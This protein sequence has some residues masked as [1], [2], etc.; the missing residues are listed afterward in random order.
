MSSVTIIRREVMPQ[1]THVPVVIVG[2]GA[3]GLTAAIG[4]RQRGI[5]CVVLERDALLLSLIHI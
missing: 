4:L 2:A 1:A 5:D 3:C